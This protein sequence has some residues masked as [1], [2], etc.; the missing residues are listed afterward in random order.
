MRGFLGLNSTNRDNFEEYLN[1]SLEV[2]EIKDGN[3]DLLGWWSRRSDEFQ[4]LNKMIRD[5]L[6]IQ[7]SSV[8][9]EAAFNAESEKSKGAVFSFS[10]GPRDLGLFFCTPGDQIMV[11]MFTWLMQAL[12]NSVDSKLDVRTGNARYCRSPMRLRKWVISTKGVS[13]PFVDEETAIGVG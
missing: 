3:E 10:R 1:Q 4:P 9:S 7:A 13:A 2:L 8:A 5:V 11:I 6:A 12:S